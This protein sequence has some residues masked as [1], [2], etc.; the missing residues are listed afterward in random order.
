MMR[1]CGEMGLRHRLLAR[2]CSV[3][4]TRPGPN[5]FDRFFDYRIFEDRLHFRFGRSIGGTEIDIVIWSFEGRSASDGP[6]GLHFPV[7]DEEWRLIDGNEMESVVSSFAGSAR[8]GPEDF[9]DFP[10]KGD[11]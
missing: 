2:H 7:R 8:V 9:P 3:C 10:D 4:H 5:W 11:E 1:F 6:D